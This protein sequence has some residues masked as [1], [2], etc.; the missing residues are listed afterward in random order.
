MLFCHESF[1]AGTP[2]SEG[3]NR[4]RRGVWPRIR[5]SPPGLVL[6]RLGFWPRVTVAIQFGHRDGG[7]QVCAW[8]GDGVARRGAH[9]L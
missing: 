9:A 3:N 6:G 8:A 5:R 7:L 4:T 2:V 1:K